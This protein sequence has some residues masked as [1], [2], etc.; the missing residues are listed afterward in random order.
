MKWIQYVVSL[1]LILTAC[2][3]AI[4]PVANQPI[5]NKSNRLES[6]SAQPAVAS[7]RLPVEAPPVSTTYLKSESAV[8]DVPSRIL[9]PE[10]KQAAQTTKLLNISEKPAEPA[11]SS[12]VA[13]GP[14]QFPAGINP[15]TGLAV[16]DTSLLALPPALISVSNFPVSARP[17]AGLSYS[18]YVF[19]MYIGEGMTRFLALFYGEFPKKTDP[20]VNTKNQKA[21]EAVIGPIRSGRLPYESIRKAFNGFL[22]MASAYS[23][24]GAQLNQSTNIFGSD[25]SDIN[26][27]LIDVTRLQDIARANAKSGKSF[28]LT[29]N[30]Y[31]PVTPAGG[32]PAGKLWIFYN[33]LN[34]V[35]WNYDTATGAYLR[36]QDKADGTG[37]FYPAT[38]RMTGQQ[39]A[40]NNVIVFYARHTVLNRART[41]IDVDL[42]YTQNKAVLFRDGKAYPIRWSTQ[43]GEYEKTTGLLRPIRFIDENGKPVALKPGNTWVE[44][45]DNSTSLEQIQPGDWKARFYNP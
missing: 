7:V 23:A 17:Q 37:K 6:A 34:Q 25:E 31:N 41:M 44:I 1:L 15:L 12:G 9:V 20:S 42:L 38:D 4:A 21:D 30:L 24:V 32:S 13:L 8:P 5:E 33:F 39:L 36:S 27:A 19:E 11:R 29:G 18:P 43:N 2:T 10:A 40:F 22:V 35:E 14:D 26:S 45:V 16:K 28:N 3:P